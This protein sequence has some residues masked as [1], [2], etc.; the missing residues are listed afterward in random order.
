MRH[1]NL[2]SSNLKIYELIQI[3]REEIITIANKHGAFNLRIFGSVARG[4]AD[5]NSDIDILVDYSLD[6][7]SSWF[8]AG[9][10]LDLEQLLGYKVD[11]VTESGL[12]ERI[13]EQVLKEAKPL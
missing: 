3:K 12:K 1:Q 11:I 2:H 5:E 7:I 4:E 9:L 10:I 8:P 6:K 13:R